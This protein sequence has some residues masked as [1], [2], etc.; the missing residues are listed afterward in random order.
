M[1]ALKRKWL[2]YA[3][4]G[5]V[6]FGFGLCLLGE[7]NI[8]KLNDPSSNVWVIYGTVA[9]VVTNSGLCLFGQAVI[10]RIKMILLG[11]R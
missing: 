2:I 3:I 9:L 6:V 5:L 7:A 10:L 8:S 11:T 4:S 1:N